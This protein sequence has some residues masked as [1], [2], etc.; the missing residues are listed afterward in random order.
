MHHFPSESQDPEYMFSPIGSKATVCAFTYTPNLIITGHESGK[1]ALFDV[2]TGTEVLNNERA[3]MDVVTDL[4]LSTDRSYFVASSKNKTA[5]VLVG[6][7]QEAM[8]VTTASLRQGKFETRFWHK[9]FEEE[10]GR[11]KG[12]FGPINTIAVH[13]AGTSYASGGED[14]FVR[15][16]HFEESYFRAK[17]YGDLQLED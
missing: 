17:P 16:H 4:Q 14:G 9:V 6:G 8:Q 10:V 12:H 2:V 3:H 13:P 1:I 15:F 7:G 11:V 5:R